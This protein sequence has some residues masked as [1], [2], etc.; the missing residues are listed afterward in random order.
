MEDRS[1]IPEAE[2]PDFEPHPP[3]E[4]GKVPQDKHTEPEPLVPFVPGC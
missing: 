2:T 4:D 3:L 1:K